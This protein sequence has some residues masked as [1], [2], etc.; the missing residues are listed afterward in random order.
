M[1][2]NVLLIDDHPLIIEAY[3]RALD[4]VGS[5]EMTFTITTANTCE[6]AYI[7]L[8]ESNLKKSFFDIVFLDISLPPFESENLISG[9]DIGIYIRKVFEDTKIIVATGF[10]NNYRMYNI[11]KNFNP[12][13]VLVKSEITPSELIEAIQTVI[14]DPPYYTKSVM[15]LM[16]SQFSSEI[17]L[18]SLDRKLL[19]EISKGAKMK[20]LPTVLPLSKAGIEK[21]KRHLKQIFN[22]NTTDDR[23]LI[24][25]ARAKGFI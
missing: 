11:I 25:I 12:D 16:R 3:K 13:G 15:R 2:Y 20:D 23:E 9:E 17:L 14:K 10:G 19:Y 22:V 8:S 21:R 24:E 1:E 18:D 6:S 5:A 7:A 4:Y